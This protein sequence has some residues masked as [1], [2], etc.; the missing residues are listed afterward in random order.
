MTDLSTLSSAESTPDELRERLEPVVFELLWQAKDRLSRLSAVEQA[1]AF[2]RE[3]GVVGAFQTA[4]PVRMGLKATLVVATVEGDILCVGAD[5][6]GH[7][8]PSGAELSVAGEH[9]AW[10]ELLAERSGA[11]VLMNDH[12]GPRLVGG[13][14]ESLA[15]AL[16]AFPDGDGLSAP[17]SGAAYWGQLDP[18]V[19]ERAL[20]LA[21]QVEPGSGNGY[22]QYREAT[23]YSGAR[24]MD[25]VPLADGEAGWT[26]EPRPATLMVQDRGGWA[27]LS[28][29]PKMVA[30][31]QGGQD[32]TSGEQHLVEVGAALTASAGLGHTLFP[33]SGTGARLAG[34][35]AEDFLG[36]NEDDEA[37]LIHAIGPVRA[38]EVVRVLRGLARGRRVAEGRLAGQEWLGEL[39]DTVEML[40]F[41]PTW[42]GVLAGSSKPPEPGAP[43]NPSPVVA[44]AQGADAA[45]SVGL[46]QDGATAAGSEGAAD[47]ASTAEP[48]PPPAPAKQEQ[49]AYIIVVAELIIGAVFLFFKP[50]PWEAANLGVAALAIV[51]GVA[52]LWRTEK[53]HRSQQPPGNGS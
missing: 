45:A 18:V 43:L 10:A 42:V 11:L 53:R 23:L 6:E 49:A 13:D 25:S 34:L 44:S 3:Q 46:H 52:H 36:I 8:D 51:A 24:P 4:T 32:H 12:E 14:E 28:F 39:R 35:L 16:E 27:A 17:A 7:P 21:D 20:G 15:I 26:I 48:S 29:S 33:E 9:E 47:A 50:L 5:A 2:L 30:S 19:W 22:T 38:G 40:G 37:E 41:D 1:G 31:Q